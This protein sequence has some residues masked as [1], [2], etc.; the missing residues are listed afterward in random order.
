M[1]I[2]LAPHYPSPSPAYSLSRIHSKYLIIDVLMQ[3]LRLREG[4]QLMQGASRGLRRLVVAQ[5]KYIKREYGEGRTHSVG[6]SQ[7]P[8]YDT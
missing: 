4:L 6:Y 8:T 3:G 5:Y 2:S 1:N 7:V